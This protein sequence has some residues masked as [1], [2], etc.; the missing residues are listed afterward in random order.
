MNRRG[1]LN[2]LFGAAF[3]LW[4]CD[5][6]LKPDDLVPDPDPM[7]PPPPPPEAAAMSEPA[8]SS[9][10]DSLVPEKQSSPD[11]I[12]NPHTKFVNIGELFYRIQKGAFT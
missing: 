7:E 2:L 12:G 9:D 8:Q 4:G 11:K 6:K 1:F 10:S 3:S 5:P